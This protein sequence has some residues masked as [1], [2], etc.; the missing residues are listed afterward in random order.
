MHRLDV[1]RGQLVVGQLGDV[2]LGELVLAGRWGIQRRAQRLG[3]ADR[4]DDER[5][6]QD[7]AVDQDARRRRP[8]TRS[9]AT[10]RTEP[11]IWIASAPALRSACTMSMNGSTR[12]WPPTSLMVIRT[13]GPVTGTVPP[14]IDRVSASLRAASS[15][16]S[17]ELVSDSRSSRVSSS[18]WISACARCVRSGQAVQDVDEVLLA[19]P[20]VGVVDGVGADLGHRGEPDD[21]EEHGHDQL[22]AGSA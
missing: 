15:A 14:M 16:A 20:G 3:A 11:L 9:D 13:P 22:A 21:G 4:V 19:Q 1:E 7:P 6:A 18:R 5:R 8:G 12:T 10:T 2:V 17:R